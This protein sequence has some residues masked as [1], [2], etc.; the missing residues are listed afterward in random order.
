MRVAQKP[1][2]IMSSAAV[3]VFSEKADELDELPEPDAKKR[4]HNQSLT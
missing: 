4:L 1:S 2:S 3:L